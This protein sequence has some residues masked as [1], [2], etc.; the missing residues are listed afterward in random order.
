MVHAK[1]ESVMGKIDNNDQIMITFLA[2]IK[3]V[4]GKIDNCSFIV[5]FTHYTHG[6][7]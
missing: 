2:Y 4:M 3:S 7:C 6:A 1:K 5:Y